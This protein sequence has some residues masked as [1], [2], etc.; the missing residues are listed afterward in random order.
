MPVD[1]PL[2]VKQFLLFITEPDTLISLRISPDFETNVDV[3][4]TASFEGAGLIESIVPERS[5]VG[6]DILFL[7]D[8][9]ARNQF[10]L[11]N[12]G[13]LLITFTSQGGVPVNTPSDLI[14]DLAY[15]PR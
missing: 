9:P 6:G 13:A 2:G 10:K 7:F 14:I 8:P 5:F 11:V 1:I 12:S 4:L 15:Q 3:T